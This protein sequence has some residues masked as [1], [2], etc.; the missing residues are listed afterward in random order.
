MSFLGDT[1]SV[2]AAWAAGALGNIDSVKIGDI[3]VSAC[4]GLSNPSELVITEKTIGTGYPIADAAVKVVQTVTLNIA[5]VDPQ[6]TAEALQQALMTGDTTGLTEGWR[7]KKAALKAYQD[8]LGIVTTQTHEDIYENTMVQL[9]DPV[10]DALN[11]WDGFFATVEM[12]QIKRQPTEEGGLFDS[13]AE[14]LGEL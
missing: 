14:A 11:N 10:Y 2:A 4:E 12:K 8:E 9:I 3:V 1:A 5:F 13:A 6:I 7:D